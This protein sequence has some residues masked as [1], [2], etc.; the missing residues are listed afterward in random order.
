MA[1]TLEQNKV[2]LDTIRA[3]IKKITNREGMHVN[4]MARLLT[5]EQAVLDERCRLGQKKAK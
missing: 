4:T 2:T 1:I 5:A 3:E